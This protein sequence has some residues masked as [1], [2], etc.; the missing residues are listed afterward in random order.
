MVRLGGG[1]ELLTTALRPGLEGLGLLRFRRMLLQK[2][3]VRRC[4][5]EQLESSSKRSDVGSLQHVRPLWDLVRPLPSLQLLTP[6]SVRVGRYKVP[7]VRLT[8]LMP[9]PGFQILP[10]QAGT[11]DASF[12]LL[13]ASGTALRACS[14]RTEHCWTYHCS[15]V[16]GACAP[17]RGVAAYVWYCVWTSSG[18]VLLP[19]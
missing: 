13:L 16:R 7:Q 11:P 5:E 8:L 12:L 15:S 14:R 4:L 9:L 6:R 10:A 2:G 17:S 1:R 3:E 19:A 18:M